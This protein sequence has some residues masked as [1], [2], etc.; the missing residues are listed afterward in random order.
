[1]KVKNP[2]AIYVNCD[3][4]MD[5]DSKNHGGVG[6]VIQ[7]PDD[8]QLDNIV[9]SI[10]KYAG[11]NIERIE[12]EGLI[13]A[14]SKVID[15]YNKM[16]YVLRNVKQ[17]IFVTDRFGLSEDERTSVYKIN[18]WRADKWKSFDGKPIKNHELLD[19]L[20]KTRRK[21]QHLSHARVSI[22]Y[23]PRKQNKGADKLAKAAKKEG[24]INNSLAKK[25][26]K[27]GRR[28]FEGAEIKYNIL[29][30]N[31]EIHVHVFRKDPVQ[32]EWEV[33]CE[34]CSGDNLGQKLKLYADDELAAKLQRGNEYL[35][36]VKEVNRYFLR[37]FRAVKKIKKLST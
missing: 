18:Q 37:I 35:I 30:P 19:K 15:L 36:R 25:L 5:Y 2:Y 17:I 32:E 22:E 16:G 28:K 24:L 8:L 26:E 23:R 10:G 12:L 6:I 21:L 11:V 3:G 13:Q 9:Y 27:I 34:I 14:M 29:K 31:H 1:M 7:F 20:D 4:A 33:W